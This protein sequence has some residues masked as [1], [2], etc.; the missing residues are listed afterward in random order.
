MA[1]TKKIELIQNTEVKF[2]Q[3]THTYLM[4]D[5]V[6]MG[7]TSLMR[8]HGLGADYSGIDEEV[9]AKAA[10]RGT[11]IHQLLEDYD[12]GEAVVETPELKAYKKLKLKV[13]HSEY[14]ISDND[15]VASSID[16]VLH[17]GSIADVKTTSE[18]HTKAVTW[19]TSIYAYL[20]EKQNPGLKVPHLYVIH[21]RDGKA[22][23]KE[24]NRIPDERVEA[25]LKAEKDGV[26]F[27]D[28]DA[29]LST[30][31]CLSELET[32]S[33]VSAYNRIAQLEMLKKEAE[34]EIENTKAKLLAYMD[35]KHIDELS[36]G[37]GV[38]KRKASYTKTGVDV[39]KLKTL[40]P[41]IFEK[42][43]KVSIV[44]ASL[45]FKKN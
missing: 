16:K 19:Q 37:D 31:K 42:C 20:F 13:D 32:D 17:D 33:L 15:I 1:K 45:S 25:L 9:L 6:L 7:V 22:K 5:K 10:Q 35:Q 34:D 26:L 30:S 43:K 28:D 36:C 41:T 27:V 8:K 44:K 4:G 24:L 29:P 21:V 2:D 23:V 38:F 14:L 3:F 39:E 11:E 40:H 18:I 12:N